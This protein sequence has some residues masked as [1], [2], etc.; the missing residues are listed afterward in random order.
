MNIDNFVEVK[1]TKLRSKVILFWFNLVQVLEATHHIH[2]LVLTTTVQYIFG[3]E[4][5]MAGIS[6]ILQPNQAA[7]DIDEQ[8]AY[9]SFG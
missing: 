5:E 6:T 2:Q 3:F 9:I 8:A 1:A 4:I 7:R